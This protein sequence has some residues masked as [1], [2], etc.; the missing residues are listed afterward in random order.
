MNHIRNRLRQR[1]SEQ[2][3]RTSTCR[4]LPSSCRSGFPSSRRCVASL[5]VSRVLSTILPSRVASSLDGNS[6]R[7]RGGWVTR[8]KFS[9]PGS[10]RV[11]LLDCHRDLVLCL[12]VLIELSFFPLRRE[13]PRNPPVYRWVVLD[14]PCC[15]STTGTQPGGF[16]IAHGVLSVDLTSPTVRTL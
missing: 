4:L 1:T 15:C 2:F 12:T 14:E 5:A 16:H 11:L 3:V 8:F 6:Y 9:V 7:T 10:L 13:S